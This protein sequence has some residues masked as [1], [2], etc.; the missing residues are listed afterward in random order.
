MGGAWLAVDAHG[1][2]ASEAHTRATVEAALEGGVRY[3]D[4]SPDYKHSEERL[5]PA[6]AGWRD[7]VF[8]AT[9]T[10]LADRDG[11]NE[12]LAASLYLLKTD[13]V[14]LLLLHCVG[15]TRETRDPQAVLGK[16]GALDV[17]REIKRRGQARFIGLS[18]HLPPVDGPTPTNNAG[19]VG[20]KL[21]ESSDEWDVV[22][23]WVNFVSRAITDAESRVVEPARKKG[24]GVIGMKVLGG[25]GQLAD[26]YDRALRYTL[27]VPGV[28]CAIVGVS[29]VSQVQRALKAAREFRPLTDAEMHETIEL[30]KT[31]AAT[32]SRQA[33]L[34]EKHLGADLG[35]RLA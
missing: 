14:D 2:K 35:S 21:L 32:R 1:K 3:F 20:I 29:D 13:H 9:K 24:L 33:R 19:T 11:I 6:L 5:G 4:T 30:G 22:M 34:M 26:D 18:V 17:L 12:E 10:N 25:D 15:L 27:S 28:A 23:P 31:L 16:G 8:L 7:K